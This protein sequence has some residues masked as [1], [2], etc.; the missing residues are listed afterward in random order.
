M[1]QVFGVII[2]SGISGVTMAKT[3]RYR[4]FPTIGFAFLVLE[5]SL[6]GEHASLARQLNVAED[7]TRARRRVDTEA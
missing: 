7:L 1:I 3:G 6:F 2:A 5:Y 4:L